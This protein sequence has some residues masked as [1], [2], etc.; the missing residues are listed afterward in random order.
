[1]NQPAQ[2]ATGR[3]A[4]TR[5]YPGAA[6]Q[7]RQ[8]RDDLRRLLDGCPVAGDVILCAS[9]LASNAI[10][11]SRSREP[12]GKFTIR[13]EISAGAHVRIQVEDDGGPW[14]SR[15]L[16]PTCGRGLEIVRALANALTITTTVT[17]RTVSATLAW[18]VA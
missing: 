4:L 14:T 12:G 17:G 18:P 11:H 3:L 10:Q 15:A 2:T 7:V 5:V 16:D 13:C 9:E 8:V 1:M 6:D